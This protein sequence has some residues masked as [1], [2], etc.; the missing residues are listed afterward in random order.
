MGRQHPDMV[1]SCEYTEKAIADNRQVV[2]F[3]LGSWVGSLQEFRVKKKTRQ[4]FG[5]VYLGRPRKRKMDMRFGTKN[6]RSFF[7]SSSSK[8][9]H[10]EELR[11]LFHQILLG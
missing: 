3:K 10:N 7:G 11:N 1:S 8:R 9:Q 6:A 4:D 2:V 5:A